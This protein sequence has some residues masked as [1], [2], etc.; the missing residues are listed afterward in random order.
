MNPMPEQRLAA[1]VLSQFGSTV[2]GLTSG[3]LLSILLARA[4]GPAEMGTFSLALVIVGGLQAAAGFGLAR[5]ALKFSAEL[6]AEAAAPAAVWWLLVR[7]LGWALVAAVG[8]AAT[9][10]LFGL[11]F[12]DPRLQPLLIVGSG[13]LLAELLGSVLESALEGSSRFGLLARVSLLLG[14]INLGATLAALAMGGGALG[15]M[16]VQVLNGLLSLALMAGLSHRVGVLAWRPGQ[17]RSDLVA[18]MVRF[19]RQG[20]LLSM[21][22]FVVHD[23]TEVLVLGALTTSEEIGFYSV[24][25]S[26]AESAM[27]LGPLI[28]ATVFFPLLVA[29]WARAD[30]RALG[31]RYTQCIR[32]LALAAAP[33]A[34]GG[35]AVAEALVAV[36]FGPD[37]SPMVPLLRVTLLAAAAAAMAQG[38]ASIL[39]AAERQDW[40]L[41][42]R[43]PLAAANLVLDV[44]LVPRFA[45]IGAACAVLAV[46]VAEGLLLGVLAWRLGAAAPAS[47]LAAP[48]IAAGV[49]AAAA[50]VAL[51][52]RADA[53]GLVIGILVAIPTYFSILVL[54]RFFH[55]GDAELVRPFLA[56]LPP[57][58]WARRSQ[59][60]GR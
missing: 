57:R 18:R 42:V 44:A 50:A 3:A 11:F 45:A 35:I 47:G 27:S 7:R 15:V 26:A 19:A 52:D 40:L 51:G 33:L 2:V 13:L 43:L 16:L 38:P 41:R 34:L 1:N 59:G 29:D 10:P 21:V 58:W 36:V 6:A 20:Y 30:R 48:F 39:E 31:A 4:L 25:L 56:R 8:L 49:A 23:R 54:S 24:A 46:A 37:Y 55:A 12:H 9:A 14:P 60:M 22:S 53:V 5:T 28:V 32:Y 17:P